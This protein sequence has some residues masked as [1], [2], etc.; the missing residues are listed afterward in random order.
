MLTP[1]AAN[2][3]PAGV[4]GAALV[5]AG[6]VIACRVA[7]TMVETTGVVAGDVERKPHASVEPAK[8]SKASFFCTV[9]LR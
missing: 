2:E 4:C 8:A 9:T 3:V 5:E 1:S 6:A 7:A